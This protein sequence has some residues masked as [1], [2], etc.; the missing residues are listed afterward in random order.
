MIGMQIRTILS[1]FVLALTYQIT[2]EIKLN[3]CIFTL[4]FLPLKYA[5]VLQI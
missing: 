3:S 4:F 2:Q 1:I 5:Q